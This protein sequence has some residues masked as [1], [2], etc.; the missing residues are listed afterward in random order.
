MA[1][2]PIIFSGPM[3]R[4]L[5]ENRKTQ[6][7]RFAKV[8]QI[9]TT[10]IVETPYRPGDRLWVREPWAC[11]ART[12]FNAGDYIGPG[13]LIAFAADAWSHSGR[14]GR[15]WKRGR[16]RYQDGTPYFKPRVW[17]RSVHMPRWAS[18]LTLI[19]EEAKVQR[20]QDI[21]SADAIREGFPPHANSATIDCDTP[22]PRDDFKSMWNDLHGPEA[23]DANPWVAALT[24]RVEHRNIGDLT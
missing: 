2:R 19:V 4:A 7:R 10:T 1:D 5:I 22:D 23:W 14:D 11:I 8:S 18:R 3:V 12:E 13:S 9:E 17:R 15:G 6:T 21:S 20:L 24:F 16:A